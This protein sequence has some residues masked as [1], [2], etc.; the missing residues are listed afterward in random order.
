M[1]V[2]GLSLLTLM[3]C[4]CGETQSHPSPDT[5]L[6]SIVTF[7]LTVS[8]CVA[9][10]WWWLCAEHCAGSGEDVITSGELH[11]QMSLLTEISKHCRG[12]YLWNKMAATP[13]VFTWHICPATFCNSG[14][15]LWT[16]L[17]LKSVQR[18]PPISHSCAHRDCMDN[19]WYYIGLGCQ[20][21]SVCFS[22]CAGLGCQ[23][24]SVCFS[25][26]AGLCCQCP[27][28]CFSMCAGLGCQCPIS[29]T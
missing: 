24:P 8:I 1:G 11:C 21:P 15:W 27:S 28:V 17:F 23:Y 4:I 7:E 10:L 19:A 2:K 9:G 16:Q 25:M 18:P 26:C 29:L 14:T 13:A 6:S 3:N 5:P 12:A 20:C 22:M